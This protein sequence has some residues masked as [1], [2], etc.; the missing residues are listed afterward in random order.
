[1]KK[2]F[3]I[4]EIG[5]NH[6]GSMKLA[7]KLIDEAVKAGC[8]AVKFQ[9]FRAKNLV[10]KD[11]PKAKYQIKNSSVP[12]SQYEMLKR[13]EMSP[14]EHLML[15]RYS[16][17]KGV[18]FMSTPFDEESVDF[19]D[20]IGMKT[21]KISSGE[22][23]DRPLIK[24]IAGKRKPVILSTGMADLDEIRRAV[25]WINEEWKG[26]K[27][28]PRLSLLHCV[29][30]YPADIKDMNI[31]AIRTLKSV[32]GLPVGLSDHTLVI[33]L[34]VASV[35][36]GAEIIERHFTLD[37][38]MPGPDHKASLEPSQFRAM[39]DAIRN[40][41][42]ALGD[43]IKRPARS[44]REIKVMARKSI[45]SGRDIKAGETTK[46]ADFAFKR[47]GTGMPP[48][49]VARI[50]GMRAARY[51]AK[52]TLVKESYFRKIHGRDKR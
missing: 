2:V 25:R 50:L 45:V 44:E 32:F 10:T 1:M 39:A 5:V 7:R 29:S 17:K 21:F 22:I 11:A 14:T 51:I 4:A 16:R 26:M 40:V 24:R 18:E 46:L 43:G 35:A 38:S 12:E 3:I 9:S 27:K 13:L 49:S 41:E 48:E 28:K 20:S 47:P 6:G 33:E 52:D 31:S 42:A 23:T 34:S 8:D 19:L 36:L 30:N 15:M 37:R